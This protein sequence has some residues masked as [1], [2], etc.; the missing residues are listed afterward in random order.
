MHGIE[1]IG[2]GNLSARV[3]L[4][5]DDELGRAANAINAMAFK[6]EKEMSTDIAEIRGYTASILRQQA[7]LLEDY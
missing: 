3:N 6:K 4:D 7:T 1:D 2:S 5:S